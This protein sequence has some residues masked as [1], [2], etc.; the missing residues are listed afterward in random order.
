MNN[1][2]QDYDDQIMQDYLAEQM[3]DGMRECPD[4]GKIGLPKYTRFENPDTHKIEE[5]EECE[6]CGAFYY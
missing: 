5:S 4:C 2:V 1:Q 3:D 6:H